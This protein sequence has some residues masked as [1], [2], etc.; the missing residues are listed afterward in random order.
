MKKRNVIFSATLTI[1]LCL[2]LLAGATFAFFTSEAKV[3][4]AITSGKIEVVATV[5]ESSVQKKQL[6]ADYSS[7]GTTFAGETEV[8]GGTVSLKNFV[9]GDGV[10]FNI[11]VKNNSTVSVKYR[12]VLTVRNNSGLFD[13]LDVTVNGEAFDGKMLCSGWNSVE[14][15][16]GDVTVPVVIELPDTAS[17]FSGKVCDLVFAVEA[18][19][20]NA[21]TDDY[22]VVKVTDA[23]AFNDG[24]VFINAFLQRSAHV[25]L[26]DD[27]VLDKSI[28]V[29]SADTKLY[30]DLNGHELTLKQILLNNAS[31]VE[32]SDSIGTGSV[33]FTGQNG[34]Q[35]GFEGAKVILN[36]GTLYASSTYNCYSFMVD[37]TGNV[38]LLSGKGSS[39]VMNGGKLVADNDR[40]EVPEGSMAVRM[41]ASDTTFVMNGGEIVK[42]VGSLA[43]VQASGSGST[44][45]TRIEING[46]SIKSNTVAIYHPQNGSLT[47]NDG[48]VEGETA[49][50]AKSGSLVFAGGTLHATAKTASSYKYDGNSCY[51]TGDAVVI[52]ACGYPGGNPVV[53]LSG[54]T[55]TVTA[56]GAHG[57]A[58]YKYNN[59]TA[60]INNTSGVEIFGL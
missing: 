53:T 25:V 13:L 14:V 8:A 50:Y 22:P 12:T 52:D 45:G 38:V 9:A 54:G 48:Y 56:N 16:S 1:V 37:K 58:Y 57:F 33:R 18:V 44:T 6:G 7:S 4:I 32:I 47:V 43:A 26:K 40:S 31:T 49:V 23:D 28:T 39:F 3:N 35:A 15:G 51:A 60:S 46:G 36:G 24:D 19:Q 5:D 20:G 34:I 10:K 30:L 21:E 42:T 29:Q 2:S 11:T 41:Y 59:N 17:D 27:V 55:Y